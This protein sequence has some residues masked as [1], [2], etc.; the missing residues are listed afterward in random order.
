[1]D[2]IGDQVDLALK[3]SCKHEGMCEGRGGPDTR[4]RLHRLENMGPDIAQLNNE[5]ILTE[6]EF[7]PL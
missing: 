7:S 6:N 3:N 2:F 5:V 4:G 1:M